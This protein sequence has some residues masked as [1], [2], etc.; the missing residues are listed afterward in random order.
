VILAAGS[1]VVASGV[2]LVR[3]SIG[4]GVA[5]AMLLPIVL[6]FGYDLACTEL[7]E[8]RR[9][10]DGYAV[11]VSS[12]PPDSDSTQGSLVDCDDRYL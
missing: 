11:I 1:L 7:P 6:G 4:V 3:L 8:P 9:L 12:S 2:N 10:K 5:N